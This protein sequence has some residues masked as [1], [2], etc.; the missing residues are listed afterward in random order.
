M[1]PRWLVANHPLRYLLDGPEPHAH[2]MLHDDNSHD[3]VTEVEGSSS[4]ISLS[5]REM[6]SSTA[7]RREMLTMVFN[8]VLSTTVSNTSLCSSLYN[9][10][11]THRANCLSASSMLMPPKPGITA[12]QANAGLGPVDEVKNLSVYNRQKGGRKEAAQ[13]KDPTAYALCKSVGHMQIATCDCGAQVQNDHKI[14]Y[15]HR[16][17][18]QHKEWLEKWRSDNA[19]TS[20]CSGQKRSKD[21]ESVS[22]LHNKKAVPD[23][24]TSPVIYA[25]AFE[26][27]TSAFIFVSVSK[28]EQESVQQAMTKRDEEKVADVSGYELFVSNFKCLKAGTWLNSETI[29]FYFNM[30]YKPAGIFICNSHVIRFIVPRSDDKCGNAALQHSEY[31]RFTLKW[32][33]NTAS[34]CQIPSILMLKLMLFPYCIDDV[35]WVLIVVD[36]RGKN[37]TLY[38]SFATGN[39]DI[40]L[41][42]L[43]AYVTL[44]ATRDKIPV[45][46]SQWQVQV[47]FT[48]HQTRAKNATECGVFMIAHAMHIMHDRARDILCNCTFENILSFRQRIA[49]D[50]L[51]GK[52]KFTS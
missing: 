16:R 52:I 35:H 13:S 45:C 3:I 5:G 24:E 20:I 44:Q 11:V 39:H 50:I 40:A 2:D 25:P 28:Q 33:K 18:A 19:G 51:N 14:M 6:P 10:L 23:D 4:V 42:K 27:Q 29:D 46:N 21:F 7:E 9:F 17:T 34:K 43:V 32:A 48:A 41:S 49:A 37:I 8:D 30:A 31:L 15:A 1:H 26:C 22:L 36:F 12:A 38:D 47:V